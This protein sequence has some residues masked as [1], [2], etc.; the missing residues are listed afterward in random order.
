MRKEDENKTS[1]LDLAMNMKLT[2]IPIV[3]GGLETVPKGLKKRFKELKIKGRI[4]TIKTT[5]LLRLV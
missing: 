3:D 5:V 4:E 2:V 1:N